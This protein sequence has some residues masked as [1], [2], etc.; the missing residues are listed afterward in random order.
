MHVLMTLIF[1][2]FDITYVDCWRAEGTAWCLTNYPV[3]TTNALDSILI[4]PEGIYFL[5]F[6]IKIL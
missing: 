4:V 3:A 1:S 6:I 5:V 2:H